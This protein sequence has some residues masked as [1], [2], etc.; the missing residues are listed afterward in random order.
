MRR[1]IISKVDAHVWTTKHGLTGALQLAKTY[2]DQL[3]VDN[4]YSLEDESGEMS[5][6]E[7]D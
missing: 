7:R 6:G 5:D 3:C 4:R 1:K 2:I